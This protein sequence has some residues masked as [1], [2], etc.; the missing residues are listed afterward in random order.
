MRADGDG[1]ED[2]PSLGPALPSL[3][4][5]SKDEDEVVSGNG[6]ASVLESSDRKRRARESSCVRIC[7]AMTSRA[8]SLLEPGTMMSACFEVLPTIQFDQSASVLQLL[9]VM[10]AQIICKRLTL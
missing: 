4:S 7:C 10:N 2:A 1:P 3:S 9:H 6:V 5:M 8:T